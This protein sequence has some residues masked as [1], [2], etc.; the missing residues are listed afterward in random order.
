EEGIAA[1][2]KD[3]KWGFIDKSGKLVIEYQF[4]FA[5]GFEEGLSVVHKD[6]KRGFIDKS[7][8]IVIGYHYDIAGGFK[9]GLA[10]VENFNAIGFIDKSGN[11]VIDYQFRYSWGFKEGLAPVRGYDKWGYIDKSGNLVIDY[12]FRWARNFSKGLAAVLKDDKWGFIDKLG[13]LI[14]DY[15]FDFADSFQE[16]LAAVKNND[17]MG[18]IDKSGNLIIDYQFDL[19]NGFEEGLAAVEKDDKW[20]FIDKSGKIVIESQF[21][22]AINFHEGLAAVKKD[23]K[24]GFINVISPKELINDY[25]NENLFQWQQK[26]KFEKIDDFLVRVNEET[27]VNKIKIFAEEAT[28]NV[29]YEY[30]DWSNVLAEYDAENET[31]KLKVERL[32]PIYLY[33]PIKEAPDFD[34]NLHNLVFSDQKYLLTEDNKFAVT[35]MKIMNPSNS[36]IYVYDYESDHEFNLTQVELDF[37]PIDIALQTTNIKKPKEK[38]TVIDLGKSDIDINIPTTSQINNNSFAVIIGN[39]N[40]SDE[41][42]VEYALNDAG[43]FYEYANKTLGIPEKQ[44]H[45]VEDATYIEMLNEIEWLNE[46]AESFGN[47]AKLIFYYAGHGVPEDISRSAYLL[48][49]NG[50]SSRTSTAIKVD[51][52]IKDLTE[53]STSQVSIFLDACFSGAARSGMIASGR[54]VKVKPKENILSGNVIIFSATTGDE[55]AHPYIEK[56]HGLFTYFLLKKLQETKGDVTFYSLQNYIFTNVNR[57]SVIDGNEQNPNIKVSPVVSDKWKNWKLK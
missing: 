52:L 35:Y 55:T 24:W 46:I 17:K 9:E 6:N 28:N 11:L 38:T 50:R 37:E 27:R 49:A 41:I 32:Y 40:Y 22:S 29:A 57:T 1:V 10:E 14:I 18:F 42:Q 2:E 33:V 25:I 23:N 13:N 56:Q 48:P 53:Y 43:T 26:G 54:S 51:D 19:T 15:Q 47:D 8:N 36:K 5:T 12:Q 44:I 31:F 16:G 30:C 20:G 34:A 4:D 7:G 45:L 39:E 21:E 3:D